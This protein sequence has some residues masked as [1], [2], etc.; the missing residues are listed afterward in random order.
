MRRLAVFILVMLTAVI[1]Q[2]SVFA[3]ATLLGV[4]P[5]LI[6]VVVISL[7]LLQGPT[8]GATAG[9][10]GGLLRDLLLEAP[11][12][13]T[14]LAFLVVGYVVGSIR[15][16]VQS[17]S[18]LLPI[19]GVFLGSFAGSLLYVVVSILLGVTP[20]SAGR[21]LRVVLL[22]SVYNTLLVPFVYPLV[23]RLGTIYPSE[24]VFKW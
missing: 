9:F 4:T 5:D 23:R 13:V 7:A 10:G 8:I 22:T 15:P 17:T 6:L 3:R 21:I 24:K 12:G 18:V 14:G 20:D 1:L 16:Y 2:T 19:I 11:K